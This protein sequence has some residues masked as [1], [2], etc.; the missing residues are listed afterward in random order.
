MSGKT[1]FIR[2]NIVIDI[3]GY[4]SI[5]DMSQI[6]LTTFW[7]PL[8]IWLADKFPKW[9]IEGHSVWQIDSTL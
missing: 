1:E 8:I 6:E 5:K 3:D 9:K 4:S 7:E 2:P